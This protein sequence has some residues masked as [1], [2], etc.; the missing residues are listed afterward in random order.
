V[1]VSACASAAKYEHSRDLLDHLVD[2]QQYEL[3][4]GVP[5]GFRRLEVDNGL[6]LVG[7]TTG[8]SPGFAPLRILA[9]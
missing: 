6:D 1:P 3:R 4:D 2:A 9:T 5:K 8:R 7:C